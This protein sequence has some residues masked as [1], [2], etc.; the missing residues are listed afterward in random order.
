MAGYNRV[1]I[2]GN[3]T[4]DPELDHFD[5]GTART[6]LGLAVN[7]KYKTPAGE[8]REEVCFVD[9]D[10]YERLAEVVCEYLGVGHEVLVEGRLT[11]HQWE[12]ETGE[13]RSKHRIRAQNIQFLRSPSRAAGEDGGV[14]E[15]S[16]AASPPDWTGGAEKFTVKGAQAVPP[17]DSS[18]GQSSDDIPF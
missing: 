16:R 10:A 8:E 7:R 17:N 1:I 12:T 2:L 4:W 9:V 3:L 18:G 11:F 6:R 5:D 13:K 15:G 14:H